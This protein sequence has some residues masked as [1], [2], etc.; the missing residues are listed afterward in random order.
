MED[1]LERLESAAEYNLDEMTKGLPVGR[2]RCHCGE[3]ED[4]SYAAPSSN[5]PYCSPMC[6]KCLDKID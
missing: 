4:L 1:F 2:F 3:V 6:R 5:N